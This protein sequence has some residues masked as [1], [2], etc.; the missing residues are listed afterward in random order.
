MLGDRGR[1]GAA[2]VADRHA[3]GARRVEVVSVVAGAQGLHEL[4]LWRLGVEFR[5]MLELAGAD[6]ELGVLEEIP[7]FGTAMR[8]A[9][10]LVA[11]RNQIMGDL[12]GFFGMRVWR[13]N[14]VGHWC[15]SSWRG[16][17]RSIVA[18]A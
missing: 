8:R 11:R 6:V 13:Q 17:C 5:T 4:Q 7:E 10:Q 12:E 2:I 16:C 18:I 14:A 3:R 1:V 15:V 9:D